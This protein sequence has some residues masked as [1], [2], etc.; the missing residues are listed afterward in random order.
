MSMFNDIVWTE[1][2]VEETCFSNSDG[3]KLYAQKPPQGSRHSS[4]ME[5]KLSGMVQEITDRKETGIPWRPST[6]SSQVSV[7]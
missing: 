3:V 5:Q 7:L 6:L 4:D 1:R 2:N